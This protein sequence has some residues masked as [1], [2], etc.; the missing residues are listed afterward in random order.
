MDDTNEKCL[1]LTFNQDSSLFCIGTNLGF[2]VY[3]SFPLKCVGKRDIQGGIGIIEILNSTNI[4]AFVGTGENPQFGPNKVILWDELHQKVVNQLIVSSNVKN[5]KIKRTKIFIIEEDKIKVFTLGNYEKI[6]SLKTYVNRN[7]IFGISLEPKLNIIAYPSPDIGKIII[8]DYDNKKDGN[9]NV[10]CI[11]AHKNEIIALVMN[12]DGS[13]IASASEKGTI[14]KIFKTK[15]GTLLQELRRGTEPAE[16]YS[17]VFNIN[18]KYI[19]CSSNKGTVHIF[20]IKNDQT[21]EN[22]TKNQKSF[23]GNVVS[24]IGI[25]NEYL[26]SEWS[27]AK[28][29]L[30]NKEKNIASFTK[31]SDDTIIVITIDGKYYQSK[32]DDKTVA[33]CQTCFEEEILKMETEKKE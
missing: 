4:F 22:E 1:Y 10:N 28:Y 18:S 32:F 21:N 24:Y 29:R 9:F 8:K 16:I 26:N 14:I 27:F 12:Y 7:G 33:E 3:N 19:A 25:Q 6:D 13:L 11:N 15:D 31:E 30:P 23:L 2:R 20:N 5:I 17:L